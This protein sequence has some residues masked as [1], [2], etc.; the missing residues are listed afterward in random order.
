MGGGGGGRGRGRG[1]V[2]REERIVYE[3][4]DCDNAKVCMRARC[5]VGVQK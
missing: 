1:R 3:S 4:L 2:G 5:N